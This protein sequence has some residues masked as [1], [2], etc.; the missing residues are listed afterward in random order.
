MYIQVL[1]QV[2]ILA[3]SFVLA[4]AVARSQALYI[5][6][7]IGQRIHLVD[8]RRGEVIQ[9]LKTGYSPDLAVSPDGS[10]LYVAYTDFDS[11]EPRKL[12][13]VDTATGRFLETVDNPDAPKWD[14]S[15][16]F[17]SM[18]ISANGKRLYVL[19]RRSLPPSTD[20]HF[21]STFD[22]E[23][24]A[25]LS[26]VANV[27]N[28][29]GS[30]LFPGKEPA[31][32]HVTCLGSNSVH[33]L[34]IGDDGA[35]IS[36][37]ALQVE[38]TLLLLPDGRRFPHDGANTLKQISYSLSNGEY[39]YFTRAKGQLVKIDLEKKKI[40]S[41]NTKLPDG[42]KPLTVSPGV[43]SPDGNRLFVPCSRGTAYEIVEYNTQTMRRQ[44]SVAVSKKFL[45]IAMSPAGDYIYAAVPG[46]GEVLVIDTR[47]MSQIAVWKLGGAPA[48]LFPL[49]LVGSAD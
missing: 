5:L 45:S 16:P 20:V 28:C 12:S 36:R 40:V 26:E 1:K 9:T 6:D 13:V 39:I 17:S 30:V 47:T 22:T 49:P 21:V 24:R 34:E 4:T 43:I 11:K 2:T 48:L 35:L 31:T 18:A 19:G 23:N 42:L 27:P 3:L 41:N 33:T 25:F 8:S 46:D 37:V 32:V 38:E 44:S 15:P 14:F 7:G 10:R 29:P